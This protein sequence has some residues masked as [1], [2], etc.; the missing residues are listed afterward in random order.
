M[1]LSNLSCGTANPLAL[2]F[3][4]NAIDSL[5]C[6]HVVEHIGLERYGDAFDPKGDLKAIAELCRVLKTG[7]QLLFVVPVGGSARIQYN[8]HRV[9]TY[10][11]IVEYFKALNLIA[12][13]FITDDSRFIE[14][15]SEKDTQGQRYGCGCFLFRKPLLDN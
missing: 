6:M 5:S 2:P 14:T 12:F 9:Y 3:A 10:Q 15:A 1:N 13:A 7:G 11:Q 4:D 8:A